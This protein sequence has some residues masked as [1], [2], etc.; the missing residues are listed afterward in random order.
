M[1]L[2][3]LHRRLRMRVAVT[4][5]RQTQDKCRDHKSNNALLFRREN[6]SVL[7]LVPLPAFGDFQSVSCF[8]RGRTRTD[9]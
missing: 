6:E 3:H 9:G 5:C 4:L 2:V 7:Q 1:L 8:A